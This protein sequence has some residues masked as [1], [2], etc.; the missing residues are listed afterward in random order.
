MSILEIITIGIGLAMDSFA[1]SICKGLSI[2][3][4]SWK[5]V[6]LIAFYFSIFH[7]G[8]PI[9]GYFLGEAFSG[10]MRHIDH[11]VAFILLSFIGIKMIISSF[12]KKK[13]KR[14]DSVRF[15]DMIALVIATS[16]DA[17]AIGVAFAF[18]EINIIVSASIIGSAT[19]VLSAIGA[20]IG[21]KFGGK[22]DKKAEGAGGIILILI[23]LKILLEHLGILA[24]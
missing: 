19:F 7:F 23:G 10:F 6:F 1:A 21:N 17:L 15:K 9:V 22:L 18:L 14:I 12:S 5:N 13:N 8:M 20:I 3:K 4:Q 11:W 24:F 2:R 16:I